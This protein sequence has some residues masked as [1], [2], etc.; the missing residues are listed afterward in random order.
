MYEKAM[1]L[2]N[3]KEVYSQLEDELS[4]K[5]FLARFNYNI[6]VLDENFLNSTTNVETV[7]YAVID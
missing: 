3:L 2:I 4:K 5:I 1:N 6:D 7:L